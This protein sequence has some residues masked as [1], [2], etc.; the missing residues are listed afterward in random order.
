M[1]KVTL[2]K[3]QRYSNAEDGTPLITKDGRPYVRLLIK[4]DRH[5]D[6]LVSGFGSPDNADWKEGDEVDVEVIEVKKGERTYLNL[7]LPERPR[8][9]G[10][11]SE[12]LTKLGKIE[13][14][15]DALADQITKLSER[16]PS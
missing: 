6:A 8:N 2:T 10:Q 12:V 14:K 4:T 16:F 7:K 5:G 11:S 3:V 13:F 9:G 15:I 1:S